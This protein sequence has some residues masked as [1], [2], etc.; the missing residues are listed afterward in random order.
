MQRLANRV[1]AAALADGEVWGVHL[2][3][4]LG[5]AVTE[6]GMR[7]AESGAWEFVVQEAAEVRDHG[8]VRVHVPELRSH[9]LD[10]PPVQLLKPPRRNAVAKTWA[11]RSALWLTKCVAL[12]CTIV[13]GTLAHL[14]LCFI[15]SNSRDRACAR[16][17]QSAK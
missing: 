12:S 14:Y 13:R 16:P 8:F 5:N 17:K 7:L 4:G 11:T 2:R 3:L 1:Q 15:S 6:L 9:P 10:I